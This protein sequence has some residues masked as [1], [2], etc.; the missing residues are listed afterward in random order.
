MAGKELSVEFQWEEVG[1][2]TLQFLALRELCAHP[3][4]SLAFL[5]GGISLML[6]QLGWHLNLKYLQ[7]NVHDIWIDLVDT[8][9]FRQ[10]D[11]ELYLRSTA[12]T[13]SLGSLST[14]GS[15]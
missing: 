13:C 2:V 4:A 9:T 5:K 1:E 15:Q 14:L 12:Q 8:E 3:R 6:V 10:Y 11:H 7:L